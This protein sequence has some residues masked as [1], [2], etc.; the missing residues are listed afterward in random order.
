[1]TQPQFMVGGP[2]LGRGCADVTRPRGQRPGR[3]EPLSRPPEVK[4]F[5]RSRSPDRAGV[6]ELGRT[7][8]RGPAGQSPP[9]SPTASW[10]DLALGRRQGSRAP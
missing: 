5:V 2:C 8:S 1:M 7:G 9:S 6:A 4:P 3:L 10:N